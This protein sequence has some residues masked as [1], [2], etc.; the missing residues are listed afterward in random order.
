MTGIKL[1]ATRMD[2]HVRAFASFFFGTI[3]H[4]TCDF[5]VSSIPIFFT[6]SYINLAF[7]FSISLKLNRLGHGDRNQDNFFSFCTWLFRA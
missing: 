2:V 7:P 5:S 3:I 1:K 6:V 4:M